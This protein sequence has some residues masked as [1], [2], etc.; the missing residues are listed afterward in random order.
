MLFPK[1]PPEIR[2]MIWEHTWP[3]PRLID[4][5]S[6]FPT[7][8]LTS[9]TESDTSEE[10]VYTILHP[11]GS[12]SAALKEDR[13]WRIL[14]GPFKKCPEPVALQVCQESRRHTRTNYV[15]ISHAYTPAG[16]FYF[17]PSRDVL[18]L[19]V[20]VGDEDTDVD[21]EDCPLQDSYAHQ[22]DNV[23]TV[24]IDDSGWFDVTPAT[25]TKF[26]QTIFHGLKTIRILF[27]HGGKATLNKE[28]IHECA[29]Q[30]RVDYAKLSLRYP[31]WI[32]KTLE[33]IDRSG[34]FY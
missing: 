24:L 8:V 20:G 22:L 11:V 12:L 15:Y 17:S 34:Q 13:G 5:A 21:D 1:L 32:L 30:L 31:E 9:E 4:A 3:A 19:L 2:L 7:S 26:L 14:E 18:Y 27:T 6:Y 16:S 25:Y 33:F 10:E 28:Q 29:N 23:E